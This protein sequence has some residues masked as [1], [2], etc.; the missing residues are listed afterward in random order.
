MKN[1]Q[2]REGDKILVQFSRPG[3]EAGDFSEFL[4]TFGRERL[5]TGPALRPLFNSPGFVADGFDQDRRQAGQMGHAASVLTP[6]RDLYVEIQEHLV[7]RDLGLMR[8]AV[9]DF[10]RRLEEQDGVPIRVVDFEEKDRSWV[11]VA[12]TQGRDHHRVGGPPSLP[13]PVRLHLLGQQLFRVQLEAEAYRAG[14]L[15]E[16]TPGAVQ[17]PRFRGLCSSVAYDLRRQGFPPH[18]ID[19]ALQGGLALV[20]DCLCNLPLD[21]LVETRLR[22]QLPILAPAQFLALRHLM[23]GSRGLDENADLRRVLPRPLW[24]ALLAMD[25]ALRVFWDER[26]GGATEFAARSRTLPTFELSLR[27]VRQWEANSA[28]FRPRDHYGLVDGFA[29]LLGLEGLY[30][31]RECLVEHEATGEQAFSA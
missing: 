2:L 28:Q 16:L 13:E 20:R 12:W 27:L 23:A 8:Q 24:R 17:E 19:Q 7:R 29:T 25:G 26:F 3:V 31:A 14:R 4:E 22:A 10:R 15:R 30:E 21:L 11:Q 1:A 6:A 9:E 5:P 18:V